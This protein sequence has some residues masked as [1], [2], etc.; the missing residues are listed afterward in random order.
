MKALTVL[1]LITGLLVSTFSDA[2]AAARR[3]DSATLTM[4][5]QVVP[6]AEINVPLPDPEE[7]SLYVD[8]KEWAKQIASQHKDLHV[9]RGNMNGVDTIMLTKVCE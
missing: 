2:Y 4:S 5:I 9:T 8:T 3:S 6:R 7:K 1:V